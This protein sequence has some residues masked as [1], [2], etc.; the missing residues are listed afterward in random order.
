MRVIRCDMCGADVETTAD[1]P[2]VVMS[3]PVK[4]RNL[5]GQ[6]SFEIINEQFRSMEGAVIKVDFCREC[7]AGMASEDVRS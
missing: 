4:F 5:S 7:A 2:L 3:R 6:F 1:K